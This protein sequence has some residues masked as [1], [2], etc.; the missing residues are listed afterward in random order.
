MNIGI[1]LWVIHDAISKWLTAEYPVFELLLMRSVFSLPL[2]LLVIRLEHGR[3]TLATTRFWLLVL[4]GLLSV[5]SFSL[6]LLGLRLMPLASA[7]AIGMSAPLVIAVLSGPLLKEPPTR[8]QLIAVGVG[9]AAVMVML[10]PGGDIPLAGA[11]VMLVSTLLFSLAMIL[12][13]ALGRTESAGVMTFYASM[14]LLV[15]GGLVVPFVWVTPSPQ[16]FGL[17]TIAGVL[18]AIALYATTQACRL[19]PVSLIVPFEYTSL[20]WALILGYLVWSEIPALS[21]IL[22]AVV[23]VLSGLYLV[24]SEARSDH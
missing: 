24:R 13:R 2:L 14:V 12:T 8:A 16:G 11:A 7:F 3:F 22:S 4:R 9:F 1:L 19:A 15:A 6:F 21:V 17:M 23:V 10:R 5:A 18:S 20:V